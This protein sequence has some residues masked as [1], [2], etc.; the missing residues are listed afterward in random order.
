MNR[1]QFITVEGIEGVGKTTAMDFLHSAVLCCAVLCCAVLR[2]RV[3]VL[4]C[5]RVVVLLCCSCVERLTPRDASLLRR[6]QSRKVVGK[7]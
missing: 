6:S 4:L 5:C 3:V 7:L 2:C 1:G